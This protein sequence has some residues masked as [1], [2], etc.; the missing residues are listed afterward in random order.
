MIT[1]KVVGENVVRREIFVSF[2]NNKS[3]TVCWL[4]LL[5]ANAAIG[6]FRVAI[7]LCFKT[8]LRGK[9]FK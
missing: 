6:H 7:C 2:L 1:Y 8:S 5:C 3:A 4:L 9:L